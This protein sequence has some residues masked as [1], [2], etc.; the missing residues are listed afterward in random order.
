METDSQSFG[1]SLR[2]R[3]RQLASL[4]HEKHSG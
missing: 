3:L 1:V 2:W 4:L